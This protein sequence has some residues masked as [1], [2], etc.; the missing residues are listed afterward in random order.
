ME[1]GG[2]QSAGLVCPLDCCYKVG[3]ITDLIFV[4]SPCFVIVSFVFVLEGAPMGVL[5]PPMGLSGIRYISGWSSLR[6]T[7]A[8]GCFLISEMKNALTGVRKPS[9][10]RKKA[11]R[12]PSHSL[13]RNQRIALADNALSARRVYPIGANNVNE[14]H[15]RKVVFFYG[16]KKCSAATR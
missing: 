11:V 13:S 2:K 3:D 5:R 16:K 12:L 15:Q 10:I 4:T 9:K 14:C 8:R 1:T 7:R 6:A